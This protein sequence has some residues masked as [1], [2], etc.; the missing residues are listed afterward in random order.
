MSLST[1]IINNEGPRISE[2]TFVNIP[3]GSSWTVLYVIV[4]GEFNLYTMY[5]DDEQ[6]LNTIEAQ[7]KYICIF[8]PAHTVTFF[9]NFDKIFNAHLRTTRNKIQNCLLC[10]M[11]NVKL[12]IYHCAKLLWRQQSSCKKYLGEQ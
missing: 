1:T 7:M 9:F 10:I 5:L 12:G 4:V 8:M 6:G 3:Y 11:N 2:S